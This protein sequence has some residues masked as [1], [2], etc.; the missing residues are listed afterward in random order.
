[1]TA[2]FWFGFAIG[3]MMSLAVTNIVIAAL[4]RRD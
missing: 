4:F 2:D 3:A 1:M